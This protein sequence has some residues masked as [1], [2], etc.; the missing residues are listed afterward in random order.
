MGLTTALVAGKYGAEAGAA[1]G[2]IGSPAGIIVGA[3][4]GTTI[5]TELV[6]LAWFF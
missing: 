6:I 4:A 5:G 1:I 3:I 2:S